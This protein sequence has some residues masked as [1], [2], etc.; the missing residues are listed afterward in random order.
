M[1]KLFRASNVVLGLLCAMYFI[2]Y[3]GRAN[4]GAA[5]DPIKTEFHFTNTQ[6]GFAFSSFAYTYLLCQVFGGLI[7]DRFGARKTLVVCGIIWA[8]ATVL[9]GLATGMVSLFIYRLILGLGEGATFPAATQAMR[10]W[11]PPQRRGL[12]QGLVHSFSRMGNTLAAPVV[13]FLTLWQGWRTAF[14]VV[15]LVAFAWVVVWGLYFRDDPRNHAAVTPEELAELPPAK[16]QK[17][18]SVP[19]GA[20][21]RRIAPVTLTY[22]CYGWILWLYLNWLPIFFKHSYAMDLG[23]S[24]IFAGGVFFAGVVGDTLGGVISDKLLH[25][26]GDIRLSRMVVIVGGFVGAFVSLVPLLFTRDLTL[27]AVCLSAGFFFAEL[28]VGPIWSI[29]M[30]VS[31]EH[32]GTAAGLMNIGSALAAIVSPIVGGYII[33]VTGNWYLPFIV[34]MGVMALGAACA[35]L[36]DLRGQAVA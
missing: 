19:W 15:G 28:V 27:V 34:S 31:P 14:V 24:A 12:A 26:T 4:L 13:A 5:G 17:S 18:V 20:L 35:F 16:P 22:F 7:A 29:P 30:D 2:A 11:I 32:C 23:K 25:M 8:G 36:M 9:T 1:R 3:L 10:N 33:D 6:L 21:V